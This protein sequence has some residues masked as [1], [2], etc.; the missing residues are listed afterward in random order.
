MERARELGVDAMLDG[1]GGDELFGIAPQLIADALRSGRLP[2]AWSLAGCIPGVG[3]G[4]GPRIR[5][6]ALRVFGTEPLAPSA[7][8][9]RRARRAAASSDGSLLTRGDRVALADLSGDPAAHLDGP[10]W[11]RS[12]AA[13][14][15]GAGESFDVAG[16]LRREAIAGGIDRRHPFAFDRDLVTG[17]LRN[18]PQMQFDPVRDRALLRDALAGYIPEAVRGRYA[19]SFFTSVLRGSLQGQ[20]GDVLATLLASPDAPV[21]AFLDQGA[22][23]RMLEGR[24]AGESSSPFQL[25]RAGM[26]DIWLTAGGRPEYLDEVLE[27]AI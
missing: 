3:E 2:L 17:V 16:H 1:E 22:L 6:R 7:I 18:P 8:R 10:H 14:L 19:K 27:K 15:T 11:W 25:W 23:D 13:E 12:L 24:A 20:E 26:A 4:V 9:R 21:R 5:L